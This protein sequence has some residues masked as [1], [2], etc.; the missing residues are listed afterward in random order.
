MQALRQH[1]FQ[2]LVHR[3]DRRCG[4]IPRDAAVGDGH[5]VLQF[6]QVLRD[7]LIASVDMTFDHQADDR[8]VAF[9]DL[10]GDVLHHQ[11]LQRRV[12]VGV[13]VAAVDHDVRR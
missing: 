11:R 4:A 5:A 9:E 3:T 10:V 7:R 12:L 8:L 13:G 6:A 2:F 1:V